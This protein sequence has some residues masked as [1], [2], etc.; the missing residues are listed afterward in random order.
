MF[1]AITSSF[2]IRIFQIFSFGSVK[3]TY[4]FSVYQWLLIFHITADGLY[5]FK[6]I[7]RAIPAL[8]APPLQVWSAYFAS[9]ECQRTPPFANSPDIY[10]RPS[11]F[12]KDKNFLW[13]TWVMQLSSTFDN[14]PC[15]LGISAHSSILCTQSVN[16]GPI[17]RQNKRIFLQSN[18]YV[19]YVSIT[20][21]KLGAQ[22]P[23]S[24]EPSLLHSYHNTKHTE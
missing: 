11:Y 10:K 18:H 6:T 23:Y 8:F 13:Q 22:L 15:A 12:H 2:A 7:Y 19:I 20:R 1:L 5:I 14:S 21:R 17:S 4:Y 16:S 3:H 24:D 9:W